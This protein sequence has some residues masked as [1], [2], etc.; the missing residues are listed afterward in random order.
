MRHSRQT[1]RRLSGN[2]ELPP[3]DTRL[4]YTILGTAM[5]EPVVLNMAIEQLRDD[6]FYS[7]SCQDIF[8]VMKSMVNSKIVVDSVA[9]ESRL[10]QMNRE[11]LLLVIGDIAG[12]IGVIEHCEG[13]I[14]ELSQIAV[15]RRLD[16]VGMQMQR[17]AYDFDA[18]YTEVIDQCESMVQNAIV[19]SSMS[20]ESNMTEVMSMTVDHLHK[21]HTGSKFGI[22]TTFPKLD[23]F[24]CGYEPAQL[25]IVAGRPSSGKTSFVT[26]TALNLAINEKIPVAIFSLETSKVQL[27]QRML[28]QWS[29]INL[30][31]LRKGVLP[32]HE[33]AQ[34]YDKMGLIAEAPIYIEDESMITLGE[35]RSKTRKLISKY[36]IKLVI[37]DYMQL[38]GHS[39]RDDFA[40]VTKIS[41]GLKATAKDLKIPI[42]ALSQLS[43][44][45][46]KR[47]K[48]D[49]RP[50]LSDLRQSGAIEQDAD[51]VLFVHR[52]NIYDNN[53]DE[54]DAEIIIGK[55]KNG[56][57]ETAHLHF[58][59][60]CAQFLNEAP[61]K[62]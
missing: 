59:K 40:G 15:R 49:V 39:E 44:A 5:I 4:E 1:D 31:Q 60:N 54:N 18:E 16:T 46:E 14:E 28:C 57:T 58:I 47:T 41:R 25:I 53:H 56:P 22:T 12:S 27:G 30:L 37:I 35:F 52:H 29:N 17:L 62:W 50:K 10:N 33:Y 42:M 51:V 23:E 26:S 20:K 38:M 61:E 24:L 7:S 36:G 32:R 8:R 19:R 45:N 11:D 13:Y 43:R 9:L 34:M 2:T 55:Q 48:G 6:D 3:S 21:I